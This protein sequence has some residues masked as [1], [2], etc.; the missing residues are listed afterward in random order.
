MPEVH[1]EDAPD[2]TL[3]AFVTALAA[4]EFETQT[5]FERVMKLLR[6]RFK[7][8][9]AKPAVLNTYAALRKQ[10]ADE[11]VVCVADYRELLALPQVDAVLVAT[12]NDHHRACLRDVA[13]SG[14]HA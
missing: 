2:P 14:E 7:I 6:R 5:G 9:P 13:A 3:V 10:G 8:A 11:G 1:R 4:E 12:P